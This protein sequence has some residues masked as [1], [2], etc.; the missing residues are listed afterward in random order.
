MTSKTAV[1]KPALQI[2]EA[3][4]VGELFSFTTDPSTEGMKSSLRVEDFPDLRKSVP[5]LVSWTSVQSALSGSLRTAL[6]TPLINVFADAWKLCATVRDDVKKSL[7][8]PRSQ[9]VLPLAEHEINSALHPSV[10]VLVGTAIICE[11]VFD[12]TLTTTLK[13]LL[14]TLQNGSITAIE[15]GDCYCSGKIALQQIDLL[16]RELFTLK[17]PGQLR[18]TKPIALSASP[19]PYTE[20]PG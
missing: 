15:L 12:V 18:L 4:S 5:R 11:L 2:T 1:T 17:L 8:S 3:L 19:K 20:S 13:G 9:V 7:K 10:D 16:K 14:L 6:D